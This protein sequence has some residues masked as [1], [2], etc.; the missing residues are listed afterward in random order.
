MDLTKHFPWLDLVGLLRNHEKIQKACRSPAL[1]LG[2]ILLFFR[3]HSLCRSSRW[4]WQSHRELPKPVLRCCTVG[5]CSAP[6]P[7]VFAGRRFTRSWC[8]ARGMGQLFPRGPAWAL[9]KS[10]HISKL[11]ILYLSPP[12]S[13]RISVIFTPQESGLAP[14]ALLL[15]PDS[16]FLRLSPQ[17]LMCVPPEHCSDSWKMYL[18][19]P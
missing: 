9:G 18:P 6:G 13:Y 10:L 7:G 16:H 14:S 19:S 3:C 11:Y 5:C 1:S 15:P 8:G 17:D 4:S 12:L 2:M